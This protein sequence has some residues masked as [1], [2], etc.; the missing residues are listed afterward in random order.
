MYQLNL[1]VDYEE[2]E[3]EVRNFLLDVLVDAEMDDTDKNVIAALETVIQH[4]S[5]PT[6]NP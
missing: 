1:K 6:G 4:F 5:V 2:M 3:R